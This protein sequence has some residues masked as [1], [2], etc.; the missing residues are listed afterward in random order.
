MR[1]TWRHW[2]TLATMIQC[3]SQ[4]S[5]KKARE[6]KRLFAETNEKHK[7]SLKQ[8]QKELEAL[9]HRVP[10]QYFLQCLDHALLQGLGCSLKTFHWETQ[11]RALRPL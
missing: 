2:A 5:C 8:V 10:N 9:K 11:P 7:N 3:L 4:R 6:L 1:R